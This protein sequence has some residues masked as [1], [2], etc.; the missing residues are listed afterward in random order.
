MKRTC[1]KC[2]ADKSSD[3]KYCSLRYRRKLIKIAK[4]VDVFSSPSVECPKPLTWK[5]YFN[6]P[7]REGIG[8]R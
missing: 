6:A 4:G 3:D 1:N 8:R 2:I 7:E 5:E